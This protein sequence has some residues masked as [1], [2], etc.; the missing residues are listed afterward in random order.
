ME[1][2]EGAKIFESEDEENLASCF[3][4]TP[5]VSLDYIVT[6]DISSSNALREM[7]IEKRVIC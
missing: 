4:L 3:R 7:L 2:V 5:L 6:R 1:I